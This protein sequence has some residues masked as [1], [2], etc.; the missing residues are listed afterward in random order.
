[1]KLST[2]EV[3]KVDHDVVDVF[4]GKGWDNWTRFKVKRIKGRV[5]LEKLNGQSLDS[6]VFKQL[7]SDLEKVELE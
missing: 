6:G 3:Q 7:C 4:T 2:I 1:M 5:Y